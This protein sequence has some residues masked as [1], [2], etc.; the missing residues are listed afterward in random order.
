MKRI[1]IAD[2]DADIRLLIASKLRQSGYEVIESEDGTDALNR[3]R[4]E[5]P[6]LVILDYF[7][8]GMLGG[9][10]CVSIKEDAALRNIP[11]LLVSASMA[12]LSPQMIRAIPCDDHVNKPFEIT[13]LVEKIEKF[14]KGPA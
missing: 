14:L 12:A 5:R 6:D 10:V 9:D 8:P 1:L 3:V 13:V 11:V 7:M 4:A 2:D